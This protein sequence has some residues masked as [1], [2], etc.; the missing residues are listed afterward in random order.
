MSATNSL[1]DSG[2]FVYIFTC[3][4]CHDNVLTEQNAALSS[5]PTSLLSV[6]VYDHSVSLSKVVHEMQV[7]MHKCMQFKDKKSFGGK[8]TTAAVTGK[9]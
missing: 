9:S 6:F 7:F 2:D 4:L 8:K 1:P 3:P 5:V